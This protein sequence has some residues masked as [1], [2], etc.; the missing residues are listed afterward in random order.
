MADMFFTPSASSFVSGFTSGDTVDVVNWPASPFSS[1]F[2]G[3]PENTLLV[4]PFMTGYTMTYDALVF[5]HS[6]ATNVTWGLY[7]Y[8]PLNRT[9]TL[10][11]ATG[12]ILLA[13]GVQV[14]MFDEPGILYPGRT[15]AIAVNSAS[16]WNMLVF[17][18][19]GAGCSRVIGLGFGGGTYQYLTHLRAS[20]AYDPVLPTNLPATTKSPDIWPPNPLFRA[21]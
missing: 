10:L 16:F 8:E 4:M 5:T 20:L 1:T 12:Q 9:G 7:S 3:I 14:V 11:N 18:G 19:S 6:G 21:A 2:S 17:F 15:Y 13:S